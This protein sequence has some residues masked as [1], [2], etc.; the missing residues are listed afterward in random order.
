MVSFEITVEEFERFR[1]YI[2]HNVGISL[3][4]QKATMVR[5]RLSKRVAQLGLSS[6]S[7]YYDFLVSDLTGEELTLFINAISTNVTSFFRSPYHWEFLKEYLKVLSA[8]KAKHKKLRIWSAACSSGEEP[9]TIAM[10]LKD[11]LKDFYDWDIKILATDISEKVLKKAVSGVYL[12]KDINGL[13]KFTISNHF[14]KTRQSD[15]SYAFAIKNELQSLITFRVF[16]LITDSFGIFKNKFDIIFCRNV[17]I[18]FDAPSRKALVD[19]YSNLLEPGSLLF[20]GD[21]EALT[22]NK[23]NFALFNSS[24]Y[25]RI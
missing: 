17:M 1:N 21:S 20:I 2:K 13:S 4:D 25:K 7:D 14:D 11:N 10:V 12:E 18:Y 22:E 3:S 6:F 5:G 15:G 16:N 9:Y 19:R 24:I 23:N 8:K